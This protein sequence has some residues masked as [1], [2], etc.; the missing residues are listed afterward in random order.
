MAVAEIV[1]H[2]EGLAEGMSA[3]GVEPVVG[4]VVVEQP[5]MGDEGKFAL[6][7]IG[8]PLV[9]L[10]DAGDDDAVGAAGFDDMAQHRQLG[11]RQAAQ[12][13]G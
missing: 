10:G 7:Q 11:M 8:E 1:E 4:E 9:D 6:A 5:A 13:R 12:W 2:V 3:I